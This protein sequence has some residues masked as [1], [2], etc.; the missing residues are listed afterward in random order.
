MKR[1]TIAFFYIYISTEKKE[2]SLRFLINTGT[3]QLNYLG[4]TDPVVSPHW[5]AWQPK[6]ERTTCLR[7]CIFESYPGLCRLTITREHLNAE[8]VDWRPA[9]LL[10]WAR[11][12]AELE[13]D[14][15]T[16]PPAANARRG[17]WSC[18]AHPQALAMTEMSEQLHF[19]ARVHSVQP[20][21]ILLGLDPMVSG[22]G[23]T[24]DKS[25]SPSQ[26]THTQHSLSHSHI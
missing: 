8:C 22:R 13:R 15:I 7:W 4:Y 5:S 23:Y 26:D 12:S 9:R 21:I 20:Y 3:W 24:L 19:S 18:T 16:W 2:K 10:N 11:H 1:S 17:A 6:W 14:N 25:P